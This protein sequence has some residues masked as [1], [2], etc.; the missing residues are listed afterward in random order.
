M[1]GFW[2][3]SW[4]GAVYMAIWSEF[5]GWTFEH[6]DRD[7]GPA[8]LPGFEDLV[9]L[10]LG[11]RGDRAVPSWSD[12]DFYDFK[13]WHGRLCVYDISYDPFDYTIRLSGT[14]FDGVYE[15]TM[16][17]TKG[18]ELAETRVEDPTTTEFYEMIC[19]RMLISRVSGPLNMKGREHIHATFVE[20]PLSDD[21]HRATHTLEAL[22]GEKAA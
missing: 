4:L 8:L 5:E 14:V 2:R 11:K 22:I 20:L 17:G 15:R 13:G 1:I 21:G 9:R 18:S 10:W 16:T 12:F 6:F 3:L 7:I 19:D